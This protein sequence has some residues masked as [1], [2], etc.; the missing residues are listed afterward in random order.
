MMRVSPFF[1]RIYVR[2]KILTE[3]NHQMGIKTNLRAKGIEVISFQ[4]ALNII[5]LTIY[6]GFNTFIN[7]PIFGISLDPFNEIP[8]FFNTLRLKYPTRGGI[9]HLLILTRKPGVKICKYNFLGEL[10]NRTFKHQGLQSPPSLSD[11]FS[12]TRQKVIDIVPVSMNF[13]K[14]IKLCIKERHKLL[15]IKQIRVIE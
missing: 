13:M 10:M 9:Q 8:P 15:P 11:A 7:F 4:I 5:M 12:V 2:G 1:K 6:N 3:I 14:R